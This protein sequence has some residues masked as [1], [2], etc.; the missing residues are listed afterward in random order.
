MELNSF[1]V[2]VLNVLK[3]TRGNALIQF[4]TLRKLCWLVRSN[5]SRK[6]IASLKNAVVR[7]R[8][9]KPKRTLV[10]QNTT[11]STDR[12]DLGYEPLRFC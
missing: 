9:L 7:L 2:N 1:D 3:K 6:P 10:C 12:C 4:L 8:N 11:V 5:I